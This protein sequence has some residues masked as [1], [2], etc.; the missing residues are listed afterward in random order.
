[1]AKQN[2]KHWTTNYL[3]LANITAP[4]FK[5]QA[6]KLKWIIFLLIKQIIKI[7]TKKTF[8]VNMTFNFKNFLI[9]ISHQRK[10][11][12]LIK[13]RAGRWSPGRWF[14]LPASPSVINMQENYRKNVSLKPPPMQMKRYSLYYSKMY[15]KVQ[16]L[17]IAI[18]CRITVDRFMSSQEVHIIRN[19]VYYIVELITIYIIQLTSACF[20][21]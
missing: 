7:E 12:G 11:H 19:A 1:M 14:V 9:L 17:F 13:C 2:K 16:K 10:R 21:C 8:I 15:Y 5:V 3:L 20:Y 6:S 4:L 18:L